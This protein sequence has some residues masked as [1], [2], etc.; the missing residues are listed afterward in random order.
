MLVPL[1]LIYFWFPRKN[2]REYIV[3][4]INTKQQ[5]GIH[6]VHCGTRYGGAGVMNDY[7]HF[8]F[9]VCLALFFSKKSHV[10]IP[11]SFLHHES[12]LPTGSVKKCHNLSLT[13]L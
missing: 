2:K 8:W 12:S 10:K 11:F 1:E 5:E 7:T 13:S 4:D 3:L 9:V 6:T